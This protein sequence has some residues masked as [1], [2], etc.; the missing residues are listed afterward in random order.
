MAA[1]EWLGSAV[2][3]P[4]EAAPGSYVVDR[5][6]EGQVGSMTRTG[7]PTKALVTQS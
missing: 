6:P 7:A 2:H 5:V 1:P 4:L 3:P